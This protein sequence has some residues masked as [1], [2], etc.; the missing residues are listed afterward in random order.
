MNFGGDMVLPITDSI[1]YS[2]MINDS[3]IP[4]A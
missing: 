3:K 4:V 1:G 2:V